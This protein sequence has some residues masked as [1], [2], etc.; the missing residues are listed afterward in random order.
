[1]VA[2]AISNPKV[3]A[4]DSESLEIILWTAR[5]LNSL[6]KREL[7]AIVALVSPRML[8]DTKNDAMA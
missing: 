8:S 5:W 3:F 4:L 2:S 1:M 7:A 6:S